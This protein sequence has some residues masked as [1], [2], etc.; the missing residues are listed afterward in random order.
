M[1]ES[2]PEPDWSGH[3]DEVRRI[4]NTNAEW[5]D[6]RIGDGNDFQEM[7][8]EPTTE[9]LLE[10]IPGETT[11]LDVAC[12]AG[13]FGR[14]MA[15]LGAHVVGCD[16]SERFIARARGRTP[17]ETANIEYHVADA[18]REDEMLAFGPGRFDGAVAT[19][20][21]MDMPAIA[22]LFRVLRVLLKPGGWFVF[23]VM[24]PCF[25]PSKVHKFAEAMEA[26]GEYRV[27]TGV[28]V[29]HY[30]TPKASKGI[31]I[32]GQPEAQFYFHRPLH[33]LLRPG[34][35][36]GFTI[37]ALEEPGFGTPPDDRCY[38]KWDHMPEIPPVLVLRMRAPSGQ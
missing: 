32:L 12:G 1:P 10:I 25:Q 14:R 26:D 36:E 34:F 27:E 28:K 8:I 22:P 13:R 38:L 5:W 30:L 21:L 2:R 11:V 37:D 15:Q 4:W 7:L 35:A 33:A 24:H 9:R 16:L 6:D 31:G 29:S 17:E 3:S 18:T 23:S 20:A 19:M